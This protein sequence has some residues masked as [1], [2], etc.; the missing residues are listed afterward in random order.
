MINYFRK[1]A[2]I[3]PAN[4]DEM[5]ILTNIVEG[6]EGSTSIIVTSEEADPLK[7]DAG[8]TILGK[9]RFT[10]NLQ[11]LRDSTALAQLIAWRDAQTTLNVCA[12]GLDGAIL[13]NNLKLVANETFDNTVSIGL[14]VTRDAVFGFNET[15]F[16][17]NANLHIGENFLG[18]YD[19][20]KGN[21]T[22]LHGFTRT[23]GST[24]LTATE[25][26]GVQTGTR[27]VDGNFNGF[28]FLSLSGNQ[29]IFFPF[30]GINLKLL[31]VFSNITVGESKLQFD[32]Y[33]KDNVSISATD[34]GQA[35]GFTGSDVLN[36]TVPAN[37]VF[38]RCLIRPSGALTATASFTQPQLKLATAS[39]TFTLS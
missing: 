35:I 31:A 19:I 38:V 37:T 11:V 36:A 29:R 30:V 8:D 17:R 5:V 14:K 18:T 15:T 34:K 20:T 10:I 27:T 32:F 23:I 13:G 22:L 3:N 25:T 16:K 7:I 24:G 21:G 33:D 1:I 39:N 12:L 26:G 4:T 9:E 2:F 6:Q 28:S